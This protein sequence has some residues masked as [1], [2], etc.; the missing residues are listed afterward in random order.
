MVQPCGCEW[1]DGVQVRIC[2]PH[3]GDLVFKEDPE[4]L[5]F[6]DD[7]VIIRATG[8]VGSTAERRTAKNRKYLTGV[9]Y[10]SARRLGYGS[11]F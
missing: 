6:E 5:T 9:Y 8:S 7:G 10:L 4:A 2:D 11:D 3:L 1:L